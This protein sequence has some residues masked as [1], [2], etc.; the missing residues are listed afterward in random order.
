MIEEMRCIKCRKE[1]KPKERYIV[2]TE[3]DNGDLVGKNKFH[4]SCWE[5]K[6]SV[7]KTA[8]NLAN[9]ANFLLDKL[10]AEKP[11]EVYELPA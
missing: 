1:I 3:F 10:G 4:F 11:Q 8:F 9:R 6:L 5:D 7:K 2:L